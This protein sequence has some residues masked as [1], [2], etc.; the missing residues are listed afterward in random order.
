MKILFT[1]TGSEWSSKIDPRFGRAEYLLI[2]D[3][4]KDE[5]ISTDNRSVNGKAHGAGT[6][7]AQKVFDLSPDVIITGNGPGENAARVLQHLN[8]KIFIN[9]Q[10]LSVKDAYEK[11]SAGDLSQLPLS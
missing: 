6:A 2:Y 11:Y 7:T 1:S 5:L 8:L 3:T 10:G 4:E 9:A